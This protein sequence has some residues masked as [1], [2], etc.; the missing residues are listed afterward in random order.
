MKKITCPFKAS[1]LWVFFLS[2]FNNSIAQNIVNINPN[3]P[4]SVNGCNTVPGY[5]MVFGDEFNMFDT[6]TWDKS[7]PGDDFYNYSEP[8][9]CEKVKYT[10][11]NETNVFI[12]GADGGLLNLRVR[13]GE[14]EMACDFSGGEV[15]TFNNLSGGVRQWKMYPN[16]YLEARM[17]VAY[18]PG[19]ASSFWLYGA[20]SSFKCNRF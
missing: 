10:P 4:A 6:E 9:F 14:D 19:T 1:I 16:S 7:S 3:L 18:C 8:D 11:A 13:N 12:S 5:K 20:D 15:K 17:K 2:F